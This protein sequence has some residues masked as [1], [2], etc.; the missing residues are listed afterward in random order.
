MNQNIKF[1]LSKKKANVF[2][3]GSF[4]FYTDQA[5]KRSFEMLVESIIGIATKNYKNRAI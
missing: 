5:Q 3:P 2:I 4:A 1:L